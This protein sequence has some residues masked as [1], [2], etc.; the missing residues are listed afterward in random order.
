MA[1]STPVIEKDTLVIHEGAQTRK[2]AVGSA[3]WFEWVERE[4]S[5]LFAFHMPEGNYTARKEGSGSGR[6]GWYWKAYRKHRGKLYRAYIGKSKDLT[7]AQLRDTAQ[8]LSARIASEKVS[9]TAHLTEHKKGLH[10]A[11]AP[12]LETRLRPPHLPAQLIERPHL[13]ALLDSGQRQKLTLLH[14]PAG[15]GKTTLVNCWLA[16]RR[17]ETP[18]FVAWL[19]L[20]VGDND[21]LRFWSMLIAACQLSDKQIGQTARAQLDQ[22][23]RPPFAPASLQTALTFLLNDLSRLIQEGVIILEDYHLI[24]HT[25]IH[26]TLTFFIDHLPTSLRI[27]ILTRNLSPLPLVRWRARGDLLELQTSHLRFS[28]EETTLFL[29]RFNPQIPVAESLRALYTQLEGWAAGLRLL[30]LS[31]QNQMM[32]HTIEDVLKQLSRVSTS[33][34]AYHSIQEFFLSEVLAAQSEPFQLFLLQTSLLTRLNGALCDALTGRHDSTQWLETAARSG[35]F[36][37]ALDDTGEWYR[38]HALFA[39]AMRTEAAHRLGIASLRELSSLASSWYEDHAMLTEAI[40]SSLFAQDFERAGLLIETLNEHAYFN[41]YH[42]MR[43]WLEQMP[44]MLMVAHPALCFLLAQARIFTEKRPEGVWRIESAE[45]LLQLAEKGWREQENMLQIGILYAFRATFTIIHGLVP[46]A[47][48]YAREALHLLPTNTEQAYQQRPAEWIEWHCGCFITLGMEAMQ[49]G[50][51]ADAQRHLLAGYTL[52]LHIKDR[53]FTR[54]IT[55]ML[56]DISLEMGALHQANSYYQQTLTEPPWLDKTGEEI[57]RAQLACGLIR[58]AYEWNE[59]ERAEQLVR[60]AVH[61]YQGIFPAGEEAAHTQLEL[62]RLLLL[63]AR[64]KEAEAQAALPALIVHLQA[65]THTRQLVT[66]VH[67]WQARA[68]IR[69]GALPAAEHTLNILRSSEKEHTPL[70]QQSMHLLI[71]RLHLAQGKAAIAL[72]QLRRLLSQAQ[73]SQHVLR[74]LEIQMLIVLAYASLKQRV[75]SIQQFALVLAQARDEGFLRLFLDEGEPLIALLRDLLPTLTEKPLRAYVQSILHAFTHPFSPQD[76]PLLESL[77]PQEQRVLT[78]L[79]AGRSNAEIAKELIVSVN[80]IKGHIKNL[81]R[82]LDVHNR[83]EAGAVAR[84][85]ELI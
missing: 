41:E 59:L 69:D 14:A 56:G 36:L 53:V 31:L 80:T 35:F 72:P 81:Y 2:I 58:L 8:I 71:A 26:E 65:S 24:E 12:L 54:V 17:V 45:D 33:R 15:F 38:Y 13:L 78:L 61:H 10:P 73:E 43:R 21:P 55:R 57:F 49:A 51:F 67:L 85:L 11:T 75:E 27:I 39:E 3:A 77:S 18:T 23:A 76:S 6:G 42:T 64:G 4:N 22:S 63:R 19:S 25:Q 7:L 1:R 37:E 60:E 83:V 28:L 16:R 52:S 79:V 44:Q 47:V 70:Q 68:Q 40:E 48:S 32:P 82:K 34:S 74:V 29:Q 9:E 20:E 46:P 84:R 5:T 50:V 30:A 66:E 62:F